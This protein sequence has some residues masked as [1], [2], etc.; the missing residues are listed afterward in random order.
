MSL[1]RKISLLF[2]FLNAGYCQDKIELP[3]LN[4]GTVKKNNSEAIKEVLI[5]EQEEMIYL[6][7]HI[8]EM[9][10]SFYYLNLYQ[11]FLFTF[12]K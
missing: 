3:L 9:T 2:F 7:V 11:N 6:K 5:E 12:S 8:L 4:I 10:Q 1:L